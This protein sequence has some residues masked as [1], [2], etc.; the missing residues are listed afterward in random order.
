MYDDPKCYFL[1]QQYL[2][3]AVFTFCYGCIPHNAT[4]SYCFHCWGSDDIS[5]QMQLKGAK[6]QLWHCIICLFYSGFGLQLRNS[7]SHD[8]GRHDDRGPGRLGGRSRKLASHFA[9]TFRKQGA[10]RK[11]NPVMKPPVHQRPTSSSDTLHPNDS[12]AF[13]NS[14]TSLGQVSLRGIIYTQSMTV[15]K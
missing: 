5:C 4:V 2:D 8:T 15:L 10:N 7:L 13:P 14:I 11:T 6:V 1:C 12:T 9:S 3:H